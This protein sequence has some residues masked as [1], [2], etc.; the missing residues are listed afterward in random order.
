MDDLDE[1]AVLMGATSA[2]ATAAGNPALAQFA[3]AL[4]QNAAFVNEALG[5]STDS[6]FAGFSHGRKLWKVNPYNNRIYKIVEMYL[7]ADL[8]KCC[9]EMDQPRNQTDSG[10]VGAAVP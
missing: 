9:I 10:A 1:L 4:P 8:N 2:A 7:L 5:G 6:R 3:L